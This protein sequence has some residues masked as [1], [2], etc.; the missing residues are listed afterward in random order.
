MIVSSFFKFTIQIG[1]FVGLKV[2]SDAIDIDRFDTHIHSVV[3][4][5]TEYSRY[6]CILNIVDGKKVLKIVID[7][8][9]NAF[10]DNKKNKIYHEHC[11]IELRMY[12]NCIISFNLI[13]FYFYFKMTCHIF[14]NY[15]G[16]LSF[17][18]PLKSIINYVFTTVLALSSV[19]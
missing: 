19:K 16:H 17:N 11:P 10:N 4:I 12:K 13:D 6:N 15:H 2:D 9:L 3:V 8:R 18:F 7:A 1:W 5:L 14:S